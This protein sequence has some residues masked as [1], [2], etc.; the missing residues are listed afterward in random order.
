LVCVSGSY[1]RGD[2][3]DANSD[4]DVTVI[5][6]EGV[7]ANPRECPGFLAVKA[8]AE[9]T[10]D[11]RPFPAHTPG[12]IDW[13][14]TLWHWVPKKP[15]DIVTPHPGPYFPPF[16]IF[17][18]DFLRHVIVCWGPDPRTI[19]P[20]APHPRAMADD[21]FSAAEVKQK[22]YV[23]SGDRRRAAYSAHQSIQVAQI[24]FGELTLDKRRLR[25][26]YEKHV[27]PFGTKAFGSQVI[28]VALS[29]RYPDHPPR[30]APAAQYAAFVRDLGSLVRG[31]TQ[32]LA[33]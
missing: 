32:K 21:W 19:F 29:Q 22:K 5:L 12:G 17:L 10:V 14:P 16:G 24:V 6:S 15:E 28:E 30:F 33:T 20:P 13:N 31:Q 8:F 25:E 7:T 2:F 1:A 3:V 18:F 23:E 26:L 4:L 11:S 27:P 9:E